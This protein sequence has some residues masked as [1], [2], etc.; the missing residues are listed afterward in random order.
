MGPVQASNHSCCE[1]MIAVAVLWPE[2]SVLLSL[3]SRFYILYPNSTP[4]YNI[5]WTLEGVVEMF[6][7]EPS[8]QVVPFSQNLGQP[9][10]STFTAVHW[11]KEAF[12]IK[13]YILLVPITRDV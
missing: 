13:A 12:L 11:K 9:R 5:A 8:T 10:L 4:F 7:L 2:D 1:F 6:C 3:A